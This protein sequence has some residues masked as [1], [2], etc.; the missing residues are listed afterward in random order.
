MTRTHLQ[1]R[2][3]NTMAKMEMDCD[4]LCKNILLQYG[5]SSRNCLNHLV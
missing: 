4:K 2:M 5:P 1:V 3:T